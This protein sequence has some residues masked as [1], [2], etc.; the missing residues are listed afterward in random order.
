M[1][2]DYFHYLVV[3]GPTPVVNEFVHRIALV[4][5][6]RVAGATFRHTVPFSF[7]SMYAVAR[8]KG[9]H[10][11][12]P[13][14]MTRWPVVTRGRVAEVRYRFHTRSLELHP[15][16]KRLS[17]ATP[18]LQFALVIHCLDDNDFGRFVI[19]KGK[20]RGGW[21]GGDWREPFYERAAQKYKMT[22]DEVYDDDM[23]TSF[24]ESWMR[25]AA[26]TLATGTT[27]R[28]E[29]S[30]GRV[31]RALEDERAGAMLELARAMKKMEDEEE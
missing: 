16:I 5:T 25:D 10:P 18:K 29:W 28:Y 26:V 11:C 21:L 31:Y 15:L 2:V 30:G 27:R 14:D 20:L 12:D 1:A 4:V 23:V 13:F 6:R 24:A 19:G 9:D 22:L 17:K 7:E 3:T 8:M